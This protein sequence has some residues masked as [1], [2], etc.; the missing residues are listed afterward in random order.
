MIELKNCCLPEKNFTVTAEMLFVAKITKAVANP[1]TRP[2][3]KEVVI[4]MIGDMPMRLMDNGLL[5][6]AS[7]IV[8][9]LDFLFPMVFQSKK[10]FFIRFVKFNRFVNSFFNCF[11]CNRCASQCIKSF[12]SKKF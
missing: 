4:N 11:R 10:F 9:V 12:A 2:L 3:I 8:F 5:D 6:R 7:L 1:A